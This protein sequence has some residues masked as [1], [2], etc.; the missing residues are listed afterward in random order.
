MFHQARVDEA[1]PV[2]N[3]SLVTM[4][5]RESGKEVPG[6]SIRKTVAHAGEDRAQH[7]VDGYHSGGTCV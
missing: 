6:V 2:Q 3:G 5:N 1:P 4:S 7:H